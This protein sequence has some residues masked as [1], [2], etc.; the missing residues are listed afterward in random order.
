MRI[1]VVGAGKV[2]KLRI[3]SVKLDAGVELAAVLDVN[4][5]AADAAVAGTTARA[6][7][8]LDDFLAA[9]LEDRKSV[10]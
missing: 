8:G 1:G 6:F 9:D 5:A 2:G 4:K 10:V 3:E 7:S